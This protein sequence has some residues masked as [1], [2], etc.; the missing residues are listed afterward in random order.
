MP[1]LS[2]QDVVS[3][4]ASGLGVRIVRT[5]TKPAALPVAQR[6]CID[7]DVMIALTTPTRCR[8]S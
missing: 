1:T 8:H 5:A 3:T 2:A 6:E 4:A 7:A